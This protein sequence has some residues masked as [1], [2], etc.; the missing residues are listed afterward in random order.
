MPRRLAF[1]GSKTA[2]FHARSLNKTNTPAE[3][4]A[5]GGGGGNGGNFIVCLNC[6]IWTETLVAIIVT[7]FVYRDSLV[8]C[9]TGGRGMNSARSN[10]ELSLFIPVTVG[11]VFIG[12]GFEPR[13]GII[14]GG[15]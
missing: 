14:A 5:G 3:S 1:F 12:N 13:K 15:F 8:P 11:G 9:L 10:A 4:A 7:G 2:I 6:A